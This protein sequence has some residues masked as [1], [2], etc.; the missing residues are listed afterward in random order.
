[1]EDGKGTTASSAPPL[2]AEIVLRHL[3]QTV[4]VIDEVGT[5][6]QHMG[7]S[8]GVLGYTTDDLMGTNALDHFAPEHYDSMLFAFFGPEDRIV[9][10]KHLPF[11][12][13]LLDRH[14][15]THYA[16][17]CGERVCIDG[18]LLWIVT[19]MPH[20]LQSASS[21][22]LH[23][24][25][26]GASSL[27]VAER[28]ALSLSMQWDDAFEIR[29]FV[30]S[31]H[32]GNRF[33]AAVEPGRPVGIGLGAMIASLVDTPAP[34]NREITDVHAVFPVT[35]LPAGI[36]QEARDATF[37]VADL[38]VA[39]LGGQPMLAVLSFAIHEHTFA[40]NINMILRDSIQ[41]IEMTMRRRGRRRPI[42]CHRSGRA[43]SAR[44]RQD[45][46]SDDLQGR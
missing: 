42:C 11:K 8:L 34:W 41:T 19:M 38:A 44:R 24:F 21:H 13:G 46:Q 32:D 35:E 33:T 20:Q 16:D 22:A 45:A 4:I 31:G 39:S 37:A 43:S 15:D 29:S 7:S 30:L 26:A 9:R 1:M 10:S 17:C 40:G 12:V 36:A 6:V 5:I 28:V 14:G 18:K 23:A 25:G 27:E 3:R 2:S